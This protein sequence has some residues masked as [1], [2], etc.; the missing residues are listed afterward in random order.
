VP[1]VVS[2]L[3]LAFYSKNVQLWEYAILVIPSVMLIGFMHLGIVS[4]GTSDTEYLGD[5]VTSVK[6]HEPWD[7]YIHRTCTRTVGSGKSQTTV[8]YDCSY[9]QYHSAEWKQILSNG[10]EY[11]IPEQE[12]AYLVNC[13]RTKSMFIDMDRNY[14]SIDGNCY[15]Y[16]WDGAI[17]HCKTR[18]IDHAYT[19]KIKGSHSI[20]G[21]TGISDKEAKQLGLFKYPDLY[22]QTNSE[23]DMN[24]PVW[25]GYKCNSTDNV[26]WLYIN[27][28]Y[29]RKYQYRT[30]NLV[31]YNKPISIVQ[32][33]KSYWEGG[34]KNELVTCICLDSIS[35]KLMWA[36]AFSWSDKPEYEVYLRQYFATKLTLNPADFANWTMNAI[37]KY[38][39]RKEFKDF[40]YLQYDITTKQ[41]LWMLAI[42]VIF[43]IALSIWIVRNDY[44][45]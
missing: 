30:F 43:N 23:N 19:N 4:V 33:Q 10:C 17:R 40:D 14:Y 25:L 39:H 35:K 37:P 24:M 6:Y 31:F 13:W 45:N 11:S 44:E 2:L 3:L 27:G 7:E 41:L 18:T 21:F 9:V 22:R 15:E 38:W 32:D 5:Y 8:T 16:K 20:S 42:L 34:N 26:S 29:G 28:F 12:Y 1:I 36:T